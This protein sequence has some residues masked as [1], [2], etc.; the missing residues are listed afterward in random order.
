MRESELANG[1][2]GLG[3][4]EGGSWMNKKRKGMLSGWCLTDMPPRGP[5]PGKTRV[6]VGVACWG[7]GPEPD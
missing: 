2:P 1:A 4:P 7:P 5:G 6:Q 3:H